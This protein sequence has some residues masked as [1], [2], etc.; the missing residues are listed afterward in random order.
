MPRALHDAFKV[1]IDRIKSQKPV[2]VKQAMD[3]LKWVFLANEPLSIEELRHALAVEPGDKNLDWDNFV[4]AQFLLQCCLGLVIVD[5]STLTVRLVHKSLQ[6]YLKSQYDQP[7]L[8]EEGHDEIAHI[9]VT[10]VAFSSY[11]LEVET[12]N[13]AIFE[14]YTLLGYATRNWA[15]HAR[16]AEASRSTIE[17][18]IIALIEADGRPDLIFRDLITWLGARSHSIRG[19]KNYYWPRWSTEICQANSGFRKT[20]YSLLHL[21]AFADL[22]QVFSQLFKS[23][24][25]ANINDQDNYVRQTPLH[26]AA[27]MGYEELVKLIL[28]KYNV[29]VNVLDNVFDTPLHVAV[30]RNHAGVVT[31]L[32]ERDDIELNCVTYTSVG[33]WNV[34]LN[35][36]SFA[37]RHGNA[38]IVELFLKR[39]GFD[40]RKPQ[41]YIWRNTIINSIE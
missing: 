2:I 19:S 26:I 41:G 32:L 16:T 18:T 36:L 5:E 25:Y 20:G 17:E 27:L 38:N 22:P 35:P 9:C 14:R 13:K 40:G 34:R 1:T 28:S 31:L 21:I 11:K 10:Y 30:R 7:L 12:L 6:D 3:I 37:A 8:F 15:Y 39:G 24:V 4:D 23:I 29:N 33:Q